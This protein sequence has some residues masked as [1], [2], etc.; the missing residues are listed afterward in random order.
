MCRN[1][2]ELRFEKELPGFS[3]KKTLTEFLESHSMR[4]VL[5]LDSL[6]LYDRYDATHRTHPVAL[7]KALLSNRFVFTALKIKQHK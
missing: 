6:L 1:N 7:S 2:I 3:T 4:M 5:Q